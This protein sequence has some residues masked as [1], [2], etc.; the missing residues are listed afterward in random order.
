VDAVVGGAEL[1]LALAEELEQ[2]EPCGMGN[3]GVNLLVPGAVLADPRPLG[4]EGRHLRLT[5]EAGGV[6]ARAVS[7][8][9]DG[10]LPVPAGEAADVTFRLERNEWNGAV[11]P[12]LL[13]RH[14]APCGEW[15][16]QVAAPVACGATTP[17]SGAPIT[18]LGEGDYLAAMRA[19]READPLGPTPGDGGTTPLVL[20]RRGEGL[21]AVLTD[22]LSTGEPVLAVAADTRRRLTGLAARTGGFALTSYAALEREPALAAGFGHVVALDPPSSPARDALLRGGAR[23]PRPT[24]AYTH[25]AWGEDGVRFAEYI[26]E[27]EL[28]LRPS[29][30]A[31]YRA[32]RSHGRAAGEELERLLRG[33]G[34]HGR[35]AHVAGRLVR[36]LEELALARLAS[37]ADDLELTGAEKTELERS[38]AYRVYARRH[39]EGL[40]FLAASIPP[41]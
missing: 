17:A 40:R 8:G 24:P 26:H 12:R 37:D 2:L 5:V 9:C 27:L 6:R 16:A 41:T 36:V 29:L 34:P 19:E 13:L 23:T 4:A 14:A 35:P 7:F 3:P 18:V 32:L 1:G 15:L 39:E 10:R 33:E 20:D 25:L 11:E 30:V 38:P 31:L 21:L 22:A 28:G